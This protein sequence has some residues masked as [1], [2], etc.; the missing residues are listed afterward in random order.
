MPSSTDDLKLWPARDLVFIDTIIE[1]SCAMDW[2]T[3]KNERQLTGDEGT[4]WVLK[5]GRESRET[6]GHR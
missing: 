3:S 1:F 4:I 2:K 6:M 5:N